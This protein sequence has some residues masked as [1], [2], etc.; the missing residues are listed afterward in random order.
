MSNSIAKGTIK[1]K[2]ANGNLIPFLPKTAASC[3]QN[4]VNETLA[5]TFN[6]I[7]RQIETAQTT[8]GIEILHAEPEDE[9]MARYSNET[10]FAWYKDPELDG[11]KHLSV[12]V[13]KVYEGTILKVG[14]VVRFTYV[15]TNDGGE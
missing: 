1:I 3:I 4:S 7:E 13:A 10:M 5:S 11:T 14:D 6:E 12:K 8:G 9:R 2:N 15:A